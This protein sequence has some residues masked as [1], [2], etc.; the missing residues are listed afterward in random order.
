[1]FETLASGSPKI[2]RLFFFSS[3][4]FCPIENPYLHKISQD[5]DQEI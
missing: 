5:I 4:V 2:Y 1:M 3:F